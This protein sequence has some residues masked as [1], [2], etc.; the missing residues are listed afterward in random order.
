MAAIQLSE[1]AAQINA[2]KQRIERLTK[3][4]ADE[5]SKLHGLDYRIK[6]DHAPC[7]EFILIAMYEAR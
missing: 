4:L 7:C 3:L 2:A 5:M 6:I 1:G